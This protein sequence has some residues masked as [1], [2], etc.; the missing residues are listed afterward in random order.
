[1]FDEICFFQQIVFDVVL[2]FV[3]VVFVEMWCVI[4]DEENDYMNSIWCFL[5]GVV[6]IVVV[7]VFVFSGCIVSDLQEGGDIMMMFWYNFMIGL[8]V[9]FW[10][11]IVVDFEEVNFGV[12]IEIQFIQNEDLDGK[13]QIVLNF[14]DVLDIF[15]QCG[16]GKMV[17]MVK[18]GQ[19]KDLI[20]VIIGDVKEEI[21]EVVYLVNS[22]DGK[23]YVMLVVVF[24]GGFFYSQDL[25]DQVGIIEN[26]VMFDEFEVVIEKFK[27]VGIELIVFGVKDVWFVVYWYYWLVLCECSFD[28]FVKVVDEMNFDD[29]CWVC[30]GEDF[31]VF[32]V[33]EFFNVGFFI[34]MVQQ[35]VG[36]LVGLIVNYQVGME[37]MGV[38]NFG[39]IG[40]LMFDQKF[41]VDLVWFL[42]F[43]VE[44]G[45]GEFGLMMGGVDGYFCLV[46]V[47]DV[48]VDFFNYLGMFDVQIVYYKVF[49]VLFVN[50]VVQEVV[51]ELYLQLIFEVYNVVFYVLQWLDIVYGQNVGNVL[52]VVVVNMFVGQGILEDIVKVVQDVVV[53]V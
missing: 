34:I 50:I 6:V 37:F 38:W 40:L 47:L 23:I 48:C 1:M 28:M 3:V 39:V 32:V 13:L 42:F 19:F 2:F 31:Q 29:E 35:G 30:V 27:V 49:N 17:V 14:G 43:E 11:Q 5:M 20:D 12:I 26:L 53:K 22:L 10:E 52:N 25:F 8:G 45:D 51:I 41:F 21:F 7:G 18:V 9:E 4:F 33:I 46:D 44:G 16:G 24:F 15:L 36:S